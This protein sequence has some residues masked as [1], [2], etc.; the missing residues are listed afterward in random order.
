M[1]AKMV[2]TGG[3]SQKWAV[4][5]ICLIAQS[6]HAQS[7][8]YHALT[9][10]R[11]LIELHGFSIDSVDEIYLY[12][13]TSME[14]IPDHP[15]WNEPVKSDTILFYEDFKYLMGNLIVQPEVENT[16]K[17]F[18]LADSA[19]SF[20]IQKILRD[21]IGTG[22]S[23]ATSA[24]IRWKDKLMFVNASP[25]LAIDEIV[26]YRSDGLVDEAYSIHWMNYIEIHPYRR[27][28][29]YDDKS[30][31][32]EIKNYKCGCLIDPFCKLYSTTQFNYY[33]DSVE[34]KVINADG[35]SDFN[36]IVY[37]NKNMLPE[38]I[39]LN[40]TGRNKKYLFSGNIVYKKT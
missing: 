37:L 23:L 21:S 31:I 20:S 26:V 29:A 8:A 5:F 19:T 27:E 39:Q 4:F 17:M 32:M 40:Y 6:V 11:Y 3:F 25:G 9:V 30:R 7:E 22:K 13:T 28:F 33:S 18:V 35:T 38:I 12:G 36:G 15:E 10:V 2:F 24:L 1:A 34:W 16:L 14:S